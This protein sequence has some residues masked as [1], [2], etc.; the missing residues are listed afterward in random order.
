MLCV[1]ACAY[2][3]LFIFQF[4]AVLYVSYTHYILHSILYSPGLDVKE[5]VFRK[6]KIIQEK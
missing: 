1:C 2:D 6:K 4:S 5:K 3:L